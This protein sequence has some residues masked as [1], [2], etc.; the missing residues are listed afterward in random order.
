MARRVGGHTIALDSRPTVLSW[1]AVGGKLEGEGP[2]GSRFDEIEE[3]SYYGQQTW[4]QA[5]SAMQKQ[6]LALALEKGSL[7][8]QD[9][10]V[11]FAGDLLNQSISATFAHR[12]SGVPFV[13]LYGACSTMSESLALAALF[14]EAGFTQKA[15]AV[16][17]SH[18]C[19]AERQFRFPLV[20][21]GQRTPTAQWTATA[22]GAAVVGSGTGPRVEA[23]TLGTIVDL[24]ITDANNMGAA[25]APAAADT[26]KKFLKDT[27]TTPK[28]YDQIVTGDL[29]AI[30]S[31]LLAEL[32]DK[33][34]I[35]L[36]GRHRDC[37]L[38][39]YD[40]EAQNQVEAG[41]SGCGCAASVLCGALLP[42]LDQGLVKSIL[43][44]ATGALMS[45]TSSQQ[46]ESIPGI[47]HLVHLTSRR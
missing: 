7:A 44:M 20:Y 45:T 18:F 12:A 2:L 23:V 37:G 24:G 32:M 27:G 46:G 43:F 28:D 26:L 13:G 16:T 36:E 21:G 33:E 14:V 8:T 19:T 42:D 34:G 40:R 9:L 39:L 30:G 1:A 6:A 4:E 38:L 15:A 25:M 17:S 10:G 3:D 11:I 5:E 22:S 31:T 35:V 29:G 47:C 41:G